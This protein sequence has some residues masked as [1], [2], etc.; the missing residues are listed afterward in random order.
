MNVGLKISYLWHDNDVIELRVVAENSEFRGSADVYV[1]TDWLSA[2]T[3]ILAGF[4][5]DRL[6]KREITLGANGPKT[7]GGAVNLEFYCKDLSG[8]V[9]LKAVIE[10][11]Y[12]HATVAQSATVILDFEP[13][14]LDQFLIELRGLETKNGSIAALA[15]L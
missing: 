11:D 10:A 14:A 1:D 9:A 5:R 4:P 6:D 7:A 12:G 3:S 8:H 2:T 13:A 15:R